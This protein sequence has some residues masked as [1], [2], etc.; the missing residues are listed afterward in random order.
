MTRGVRGATPGLLFESGFISGA[1]AGAGGDEG[2]AVSHGAG[3]AGGAAGVYGAGAAGGAF[4]RAASL[5]ADMSTG[6]VPGA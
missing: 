1:G 3:V 5:Y 6:V 2:S 4:A